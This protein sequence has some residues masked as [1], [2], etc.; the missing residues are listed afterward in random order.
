MV[1]FLRHLPCITFQKQTTEIN[2]RKAPTRDVRSEFESLSS[3]DYFQVYFR[4]C[5][6]CVLTVRIFL[7]SNLSSAVQYDVSYIHIHFFRE[8]LENRLEQ[9]GKELEGKQKNRS[10]GGNVLVIFSWFK[11]NGNQKQFVFNAKLNKF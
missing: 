5:L 6:S 9:N 3:L 7:L 2:C 10:S 4:N 11:I 1:N 8:Y